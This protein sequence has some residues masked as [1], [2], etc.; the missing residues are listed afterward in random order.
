MKHFKKEFCIITSVLFTL[1]GIC[2]AQSS[3]ENEG[4][5]K[6]PITPV[7]PVAPVKP[8]VPSVELGTMKMPDFPTMPKKKTS[9]KNNSAQYVPGQKYTKT[10][11]KTETKTETSKPAPEQLTKENILRQLDSISATDLTALSG[12]GLLPNMA[13]LLSGTGNAGLT[14]STLT[15]TQNQNAVL[16]Q[17]L[18][19]LNE[20][21]AAQNEFKKPD[22][23]K[24]KP[25]NEPPAILR[26]VVNSY[27]LL[28]SCNAVYFS[29]MTNDGSFL[30]T[31][32]CKA[33]YNKVTLSE[34][35]YIYFKCA[36]TQDG[37]NI[38]NVELSLSQ[39]RDNKNSLLYKFCE[40][41]NI[42]AV[43]TGNLITI[44]ETTEGYTSDLLL[45]IGK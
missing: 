3:N 34:T 29:D 5:K 17:I 40:R 2:F 14:N 16:D 4:S 36:G 39:D 33:L 12:Q 32:D 10:E 7:A 20:I 37:R 23:S 43:K 15:Q 13:T 11:Q 31:G 24:L 18:K 21:K 1:S 44:R 38:Y 45:D 6:I 30:L 9:E 19:E 8:V 41:K 25:S 27:D 42:T 22:F 28:K 35:F 26:F